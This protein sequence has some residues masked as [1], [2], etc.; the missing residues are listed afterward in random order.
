[1]CDSGT[2]ALGGCTPPSDMVVSGLSCAVRCLSDDGSSQK[3]GRSIATCRREQVEDE[4][5][6][7]ESKDEP[8]RDRASSSSS[9]GYLIRVAGLAEALVT[10]GKPEV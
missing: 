10:Q 7:G 2:A 5:E 3:L 1:M 4:R 6:E 8:K 9:A